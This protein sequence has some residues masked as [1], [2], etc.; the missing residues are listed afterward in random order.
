M[1]HSKEMKVTGSFAAALLFCLCLL[2]IP[3]HGNDMEAGDSGVRVSTTTVRTCVDR[4]EPELCGFVIVCT[5]QWGPDEETY[6]PGDVD[7]DGNGPDTEDL[8]Y[9]A[10]YLFRGGQAPPVA[11]AADIDRSGSIDVEDLC[12][13]IRRNFGDF[14]SPLEEQLYTSR[15]QMLN[16]AH[17]RTKRQDNATTI[18]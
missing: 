7:G 1:K 4:T 3:L 13:L 11:A 15:E 18:K 9:L 2:L 12:L 14:R 16:T 17:T 5:E 10:L 8:N 6:M